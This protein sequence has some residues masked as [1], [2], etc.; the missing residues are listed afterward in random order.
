MRRMLGK[1]VVCSLAYLGVAIACL[2]RWNSPQPWA[3]L[4]RFAG[5]YFA[6]RLGGAV[7]SIVCSVSMFRSSTLRQEWWGLNADRARP[8]WVMVLMAL[9]LVVFLDYG[10]WRF[11]LWLVRPTLQIAGIALYFVVTFCQI[12]KDPYLARYF[13][14]INNLLSPST[15]G[16]IATYVTRDMLPAAIVER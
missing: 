7:Y 12:W 4:D 5:T 11:A 15:R 9:G 14:R 3:R 16:P 1:T 8:Q 13:N 6:L 10:H 2:V